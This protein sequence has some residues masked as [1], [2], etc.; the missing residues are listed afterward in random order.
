ME[1]YRWRVEIEVVIVVVRDIGCA[2]M[3]MKETG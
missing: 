2:V 3:I 1:R